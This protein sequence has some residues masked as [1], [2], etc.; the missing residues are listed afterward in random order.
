MAI[1]KSILKKPGNLEE[2][3]SKPKDLKIFFEKAG[4]HYKA[5]YNRFKEKFIEW[6]RKNKIGGRGWKLQFHKVL[7]EAD[8]RHL[9]LKEFVKKLPEVAEAAKVSI[10]EFEI[11]SEGG[12]IWELLDAQNYQFIDDS[13]Y[14]KKDVLFVMTDNGQKMQKLFR[15]EK[16]TAKSLRG[17]IKWKKVKYAGVNFLQF[18]S[19]FF[20]YYL[21]EKDGVFILKKFSRINPD[22]RNPQRILVSTRKFYEK[23]KAVT[24]IAEEWNTKLKK[25]SNQLQDFIHMYPRNY[26]KKF[27]VNTSPVPSYKW[28]MRGGLLVLDVT[29]PDEG[30]GNFNQYA[31]MITLLGEKTH[32][33]KTK[34]YTVEVLNKQELY[35]RS[36]VGKKRAKEAAKKQKKQEKELS[37]KE[38]ALRTQLQ[39]EFNEK[40]ATAIEQAR[41]SLIKERNTLRN[42]L[43]KGKITKQEYDNDILRINQELDQL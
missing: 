2:I 19:P 13:P 29:L 6:K 3:G 32:E 38:K 31:A 22:S 16:E 10:I 30:D 37:K 9:S 41:A 21:R 35:K 11:I 27:Y 1:R 12:Y 40:Q 20:S 24:A 33:R 4:H 17:R 7:D 28:E 8:K 18:N 5:R 39:M 14:N 15:R 43:L 25:M 42:L 34:D 23:D 36:K 26:W